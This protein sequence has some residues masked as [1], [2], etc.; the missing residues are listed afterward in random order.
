METNNGQTD[1]GE[2][3]AQECGQTPSADGATSETAESVNVKQETSKNEADS[4]IA[5][6]P[7]NLK[8]EP[9]ND[10]TEDASTVLSREQVEQSSSTPQQNHVRTITLTSEYRQQENAVNSITQQPEQKFTEPAASQQS[11]A[12]YLEEQPSSNQPGVYYQE[13]QSY[14]QQNE[15]PA[16]YARDLTNENKPNKLLESAAAAAGVPTNDYMITMEEEVHGDPGSSAS[17][18]GSRLATM[19]VMNSILFVVLKFL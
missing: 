4:T 19:Q 1:G 9:S 16:H 8:R 11:S 12:M 10:I 15:E 5:E 2:A 13:Q 6:D 7:V 14:S 18:L 17:Y 3:P